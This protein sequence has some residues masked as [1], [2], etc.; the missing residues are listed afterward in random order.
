MRA[1]A[2]LQ[3]LHEE[4]SSGRCPS[5]Q[6]L[7]DNARSI[8]YCYMLWREGIGDGGA[9]FLGRCGVDT[10]RVHQQ[11]NDLALGGPSI[12]LFYLRE[13]LL[14]LLQ[15]TAGVCEVRRVGVGQGL[16]GVNGTALLAQVRFLAGDVVELFSASSSVSLP[17]RNRIIMRSRSWA[18]SAR[19]CI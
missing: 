1:L 19:A 5:V 14:E 17:R 10:N 18:F 2:R 15:P 16:R 7:T 9:H 8:V 4:I 13:P 6:D 12:G 3:R 11:L